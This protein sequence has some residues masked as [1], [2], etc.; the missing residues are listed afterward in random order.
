MSPKQHR[1]LAP[2]LAAAA[3]IGY[4]V[5]GAI[6]V[7]APQ[8]DSGWH[9][10]GY[11]VEAAFAIALLA[12]LPLVD[13]LRHGS[14]R[15]ASGAAWLVR[16][17]FAAMLVSA[18]ASLAAGETTLGPAFFLGVL[19]SLAGLLA[20]AVAAVRRRPGGWW[21][22]PV[23]AAGLLLSIALGDHG[24]GIVLGL[25]WAATGIALRETGGGEAV[26]A[27]GA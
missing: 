8:P 1:R 19:A 17:G 16:L 13:L 25:A 4:C 10:A 24:G 14:G 27:A 21:T 5:E 6:V 22:A 20:L 3:A 7:R 18:L 12:S 9:A 2:L 23:V 11:A 26:A 15:I